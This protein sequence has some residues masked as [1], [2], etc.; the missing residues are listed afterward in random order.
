MYVRMYVCM[1]VTRAV[2]LT[3]FSEQNLEVD[4]NNL[5]VRALNLLADGKHYNGFM[6]VCM[7]VCI[8][9]YLY[10]CNRIFM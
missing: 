9:L 7:Y 10:T 3:V 4:N 6:Y 2:L 1:Y 5:Y 8:V